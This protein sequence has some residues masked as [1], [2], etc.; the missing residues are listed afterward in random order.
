MEHF[1]FFKDFDNAILIHSDL[2]KFN[3]IT[4]EKYEK[5]ASFL[6][7]NKFLPVI[8]D[9]HKLVV[10]EKGEDFLNLLSR[11]S[12]YVIVLASQGPG[13]DKSKTFIKR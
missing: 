12:K 2:L 11:G 7:V 10:S 5:W 9:G 13:H 1:P 4:A 6:K 3:S 8:D